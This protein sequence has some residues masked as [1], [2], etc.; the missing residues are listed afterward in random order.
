MYNWIKGP[1][2]SWPYGSW[3]NNYPWN[4]CL[5]PLKVWDQIPIMARCTRYNIMWKV[6]RKLAVGRWFS[7]VTHVSATNKSNCHDITE[8]LLKVALNTT[9]PRITMEE[10]LILWMCWID[11]RGLSTIH[12]QQIS[13]KLY[14]ANASR[15]KQGSTRKP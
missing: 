3:I 1:S 7:T 15:Y 13:D 8:I 14:L 12:H 11:Y 5:S 10:I 2:C 6:C 9:H 4:Q